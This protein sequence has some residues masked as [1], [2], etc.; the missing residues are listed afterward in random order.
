MP[1]HITTEIAGRILQFRY[2]NLPAAA[3]RAAKNALLDTLGVTLAGSR[4]PAAAIIRDVLTA[5]ARTGNS[6]VIGT[7]HQANPLDAA[8][9]N[10]TAAHALDFDDVSD[11]MGGH[12]SAPVLAALLALGEAIG[13]HGRDLVNAFVAGYETEIRVAR[14][15]N[16]HHYTKG[17]HPTATLGVFG[18]A[19]AC[20]RLL[21]LEEQQ[22]ASALAMSAS[23]SAGLKANFGTMT[24]P[25]HVGNCAR[26][27][28]LAALLA[29]KQFTASPDAFEHAQ[30]FLNVFNGVVIKQYPCCASTHS[31]IDTLIQMVRAHHIQ[32]EEVSNIDVWIHERRLE[33]TNRPNPQNS[34]AAK[35]SL[36][37]C[38]A[39]ALLH[40]TVVLSHFEGHAFDDPQA[41]SIMS[42]VNAASY[43]SEQ[44]G[45]DN[46]Y[47]ATIKLTLRDGRVFS[48]KLD[49]AL[50]Q[51]AAHPLPAGSLVAKFQDC[52]GRILAPDQVLELQESVEHIEN[53]HNVRHLTA[54]TVPKSLT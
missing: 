39:R 21:S 31:A 8:L 52:A 9:M 6:A 17:W 35:F 49:E 28:L 20:A 19:A 15:V 36:Q 48:G 41:R 16:F 10:G 24:K 47:G 5:D 46:A 22:I 30:G 23:M 34:I 2:E 44:V 14:A 32:A 42:R 11:A 3:I 7:T 12:P 25:L 13:A 1:M 27:G 33:H 50:G 43:T 18:A 53:V 38:L 51:S 40:G 26:N 29:G 54:V 45:S 4:E 37:Y